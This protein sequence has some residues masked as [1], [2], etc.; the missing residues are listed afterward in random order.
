MKRF[1]KI[2]VLFVLIF[3][4][5]ISDGYFQCGKEIIEVQA[6]TSK[7]N[8]TKATLI[9]GQTLQLKISGIKTK[10]KWSSSKKSVATV[11]SKGKVTAKKKGIATI[12]AKVGKK[13]YKCKVTV[14]APSISKKAVTIKVG[15]SYSL[16]I[17]GTNQQ[18]TWSSNNKNVATVSSKG[19]VT[20]KKTGNCNIVAKVSS[21]KYVC[22]VTVKDATPEIIPIESFSLN[23]SAISIYQGEKEKLTYEIYP[24]NATNKEVSFAT[25]N[26][27]IATVNSTGEI[28]AISAGNCTITAICG[29]IKST[30]NVAVLQKYIPVTSFSLN[31]SSLSIYKGE[32]KKLSYTINP[33]NA[34]NQ[35]VL[36]QSADGNIASVSNGGIISAKTPGNCTIIA[37]CGGIQSTCN[38]TV[39]DKFTVE[40]AQNAISYKTYVLDNQRDGGV[41][42]VAQNNYKYTMSIDAG[43][44]FYDEDGN[45]I[46]NSKTV[47]GEN[48]CLEPGK[49]SYFY[50]KGPYKPIKYDVYFIV[51]ESYYTGKIDAIEITSSKLSSNCVIANTKNNS[52]INSF[53]NLACIFYKDGVPIGYDDMFAYVEYIGAEDEVHLYYPIDSNGKT[54]IP[55]SYEINIQYSY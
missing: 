41:V 32:S 22:E 17:N 35:E 43:C 5:T 36:F 13:S 29:G 38:I 12:T 9:K 21:K 2:L 47:L 7:I 26:E 48:Y 54:I 25:S 10:V 53:T 23:Q 39:E 20:A 14:E 4:F 24:S 19:K 3:S 1:S 33:E 52:S 51:K 42:I 40:D 44:I 37:T 50:V 34:T 11:S 46:G 55:D 45:V 15:D 18:V 6:A 31:Q 27:K 8:K 16:K 49:K 28:R 30:C